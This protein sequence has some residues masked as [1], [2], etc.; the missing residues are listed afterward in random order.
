[1]KSCAAY[2]SWV[3]FFGA[4][5]AFLLPPP[6]PAQNFQSKGN[7]SP[8]P[9][10]SGAGSRSGGGGGAAPDL[11]AAGWDT[12]AG[13]FGGGEQVVTIPLSDGG[14]LGALAQL[15]AAILGSAVEATNPEGVAIGA[16]IFSLTRAGEP[17]TPV[18]G[19]FQFA[20]CPADEWR[21]ELL[22]M[23]AGGV[24]IVSTNVFWIF[25]EEREGKFDWSGA[26]DLRRFTQTC[27]EVGMQVVLRIG[28]WC[29]GGARNG[30]LPDWL[31]AGGA[32]LRS[33]DPRY[34]D[35]ARAWFGEIGAQVKGLL[36][37]DGGPVVGVQLESEYPGPGAHLLAL[38]KL[39]I[40]AGI[41]VPLYF[42]TG[43]PAPTSPVPFGEILP[44]WGAVAEGY[45]DRDIAPMPGNYWTA[46]RFGTMSD[47]EGFVAS[48]TPNT[49]TTSTTSNMSTASPLSPSPAS[50]SASASSPASS[51]A[52][53][54][55]TSA[56]SASSASSSSSA[57]SPPPQQYPYLTGGVG[58]GMVSSYHR[59]IAIDARD[60]EA[61]A[62]V[63]LGSGSVSTGY[64]VYHGGINPDSVTGAGATLA[65]TQTSAFTNWNDLPAKNYDYQA[66]L[67]AAGQ[68]RASYALLRRQNLFMHDFGHLLAGKP[69]VL[70]AS[71]PSGKTDKSTLRWAIRSD[72]RSGF[73]FVNNYQRGMSMPV[74]QGVQF[75]LNLPPLESTSPI[76]SNIG[77]K[78]DEGLDAAE[79]NAKRR[80]AVAQA[81][82]K[83]MVPVS[84]VDVPPNSS[85]ILPFNL[86]LGDGAILAYAL[87]QPLCY[88]DTPDGKTRTYFFSEIPGIAPE[89]AFTDITVR[90]T[91]FGSGRQRRG[92]G[93]ERITSVKVGHSRAVTL[94]SPY[95]DGKNI[96]IVVLPYADSLNLY[97][98]AWGDD[99]RVIISP[100]PLTIDTDETLRVLAPAP[101]EVKLLVY[102]L[103]PQ[104]P[105]KKKSLLG[106][107]AA[108][109]VK[110]LTDAMTDAGSIFTTIKVPGADATGA[111]PAGA[112]ATGSTG[113]M[114]ALAKLG[115]SAGAVRVEKIRD[116]GPARAIP[117]GRGP[118]RG[119]KPVPAAPADA[120]F[121]TA[122]AWKISLSPEWL[123]RAEM[124]FSGGSAA[125]AGSV[126]SVGSIAGSAGSLAR[127]NA[128]DN[129]SAR[130]FRGQDARAPNAP[131][132]SATPSAPATSAAHVAPSASAAPIVQPATNTHAGRITVASTVTLGDAYLRIHYT[133]DVARVLLDGKV[134]MDDFY[135]G[136]P[137]ELPLK[138]FMARLAA[139]AQLTVE[140][141]PLRKDAPIL[142]PDSAWPRFGGRAS[143]AELSKA[144]L[145]PTFTHTLVPSAEAD[146]PDAA[147]NADEAD[148]AEKAEKASGGTK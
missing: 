42:R 115:A 114:Q 95:V 9:S 20:R 132:A 118:K 36:W 94:R 47:E 10:S 90:V 104:E 14:G 38:K 147:D 112:G 25:H 34:L 23:K 89:L 103:P 40:D 84:P 93:L 11:S 88:V 50:S 138:R 44:W 121:A 85:F 144:E 133:G 26:R 1:M 65:E 75:A 131:S 48:T 72:G 57:S 49:S 76:P 18:M 73:I 80:A 12:G 136:Q 123:A 6:A 52:S 148:N 139:G 141:L 19:E 70:P 37:K 63:K 3:L 61:L 58:A 69:T 46:F 86:D 39:A 68:A 29:G 79:P 66:P 8:P 142:L 30:G 5:A 71:H 2:F 54:S 125:S 146:E 129:T 78:Y 15:P 83:R 98:L 4:V 120:D 67:G 119:P 143:I 77:L 31:V 124:E 122:A 126:G 127:E 7:P 62:L 130:E 81:V 53:S 22:K 102:P 28:P 91:A 43:T 33:D 128:S 105:R 51:A 24:D 140:I 59:R 117:A 137:L 82:S 145:V 45:W 27:A 100:Y 87:A 16:N 135:N 134:V 113:A 55:T 107:I 21:G 17:W 116:A 60:T 110:P 109:V 74:K 99:E 92:D 56:S 111:M 106:R 96:Q 32:R 41:S 64:Y 13:D 108:Y 97:K 35:K 101:G